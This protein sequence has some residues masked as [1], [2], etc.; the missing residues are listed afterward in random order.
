MKEPSQSP[1]ERRLGVE[2]RQYSYTGHFPERRSGEDR[3]NHQPPARE[4]T[5]KDN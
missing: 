1:A 5:Q 4:S 3:R 2:R